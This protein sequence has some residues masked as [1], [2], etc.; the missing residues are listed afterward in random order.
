MG[1][2][3]MEA[4][5]H[6]TQEKRHFTPPTRHAALFAYNIKQNIRQG[7]A[8]VPYPGRPWKQIPLR[9]TEGKLP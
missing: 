3:N 1:V 7:I 6:F 9:A 8:P 2:E 5:L 4:Q